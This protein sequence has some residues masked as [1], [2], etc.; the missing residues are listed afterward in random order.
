MP[1][2]LHTSLLALAALLACSGNRFAARPSPSPPPLAALPVPPAPEPAL[3]APSLTECTSPTPPKDRFRMIE[4][5]ERPLHL[6][7]A[8]PPGAYNLFLFG[9][10]WCDPCKALLTRV[11][12]LLQA[13]PNLVVTYI[14]LGERDNPA[15]QQYY[16]RSLQTEIPYAYLADECGL[17]IKWVNPGDA[18]RSRLEQTLAHWLPPHRRG[19]PVEPTTAPAAEP[20]HFSFK[21][22]PAPAH[23]LPPTPASPPV[24]A[25]S[26]CAEWELLR[27]SVDLPDD[28]ADAPFTAAYPR[29]IARIDGAEHSSPILQPADEAT[30]I[31]QPSL[32][33]TDRQSLHVF[34]TDSDAG[35]RR[36]LAQHN[37]AGLAG[38]VGEIKQGPWRIEGRC[39]ADSPSAQSPGNLMP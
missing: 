30:W 25:R 31:V 7:S 14:D 34:L 36:T 1:R 39:A 33:M 8:S 15:A 35:A 18:F 10:Y 20:V 12:A 4:L 3:A 5:D 9:A 11:P 17:G 24:L 19:A 23:G 6:G 26:A 2:N 32:R 13:Y 21:N 27:I 37:F 22:T 16:R 29:I 28:P 38:A